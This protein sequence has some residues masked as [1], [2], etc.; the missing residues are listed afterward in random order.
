MKHLQIRLLGLA[1]CLCAAAGAQTLNI[2]P[3]RSIF[4]IHV[5]KAGVFS[6]F[7]HNHEIRG[8]ASGA[9]SESAPQWVE[10][11]VD[12]KRLT[13]LDADLPAK[14]RADVQTT[15][16]GPQVLDV[17]RFPSIHFRSTRVEAVA[18][19]RWRVT[20]DLLLHG[21]TRP[22]TVQVAG[23]HGHYTG[24]A[25]LKQRDFGI[26]PVSVAGGTVKVKDEVKIDFDIVAQ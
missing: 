6:A 22:L 26:K 2:N 8:A 15:M 1:L 24:T 18:A 13:V 25:T 5:F 14:D 9:L 4:T 21:E 3:Q 11:A 7:G 19:G 20:G 10:I 17:A 12:A 23:D 16:L